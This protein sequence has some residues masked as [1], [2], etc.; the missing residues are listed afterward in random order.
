MFITRTDPPFEVWNDAKE[1]YKLFADSGIKSGSGFFG[2]LIGGLLISI[3]DSKA[4]AIVISLLTIF[5]FLMLATGTSL[6]KLFSAVGKPVKKVS[7]ISAEKI[8]ELKPPQIRCGCGFGTAS[9]NRI[10]L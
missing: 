8:V 9:V 2:A 7:D 5:V 10:S 6:M 1:Q 3:A 4:P